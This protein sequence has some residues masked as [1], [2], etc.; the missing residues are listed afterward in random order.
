MAV[1]H[2][3]R[4]RRRRAGFIEK[5]LHDLAGALERSY[6]F[7]QIGDRQG[8]LQSLDPRVKVVGVLLLIIAAAASRSILVI[9]AVYALGTI[10]AIASEVS[11]GMLTRRV[12]L[13]ALL[14]TGVIA[15]PALFLTPGREVW[16]LPGPGWSVTAQGLGAATFLMTRVI[17]SMT[18][19]ITLV[20]TT[21]WIQVLKALRALRVPVI[22]VVI[23]GMT[24]RYIFMM[25]QAAA[26][27]LEAR[28]SRT[29]GRMEWS[30]RRR[31]AASSIGVLLSKTIYLSNEVYLAMQSRGF[32]GEVYTLD[33]FQMRRRDWLALASFVSLAALGLW[34]G[35]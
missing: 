20:L 31:L 10:L 27:M 17:T 24:Y 5:T 3:S 7:E 4:R 28:Q 26:D 23:L 12:W 19:A 16:R 34:L 2:A 22:F 33:D 29:V 9:L 13:S 18:L 11:L 32:R 25:L 35:R 6:S 14:F 21:P 8:L 30:E 15:I 1:E